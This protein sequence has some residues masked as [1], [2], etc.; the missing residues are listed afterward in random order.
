MWACGVVAAATDPST[1]PHTVGAWVGQLPHL[2][3]CRCQA[4][5]L[6]VTCRTACPFCDMKGSSA[7]S[8][9][10]ASSWHSTSSR[11]PALVSSSGLRPTQLRGSHGSTSSAGA[12]S[13][14]PSPQQCG[15]LSSPWGAPAPRV[16]PASGGCRAGPQ[17]P[18]AGAGSLGCPTPLPCGGCRFSSVS[19]PRSVPCL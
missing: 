13:P 18:S 12:G 3:Y 6:C 17:E 9:P 1:V 7:R 19:G 16:A 11:C 10:R 2:V 5:S 15:P 8:S 14:L 4:G